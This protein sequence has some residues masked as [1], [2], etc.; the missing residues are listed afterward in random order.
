MDDGAV[1]PRMVANRPVRVAHGAT[2][3]D[4]ELVAN[5]EIPHVDHAAVVPD[6]SRVLHRNGIV[7][8]AAPITDGPDAVVD[9]ARRDHVEGGAAGRL[10]HR[11]VAGQ[12]GEGGDLER[13]PSGTSCA[14]TDS[15][16]PTEIR[17]ATSSDWIGAS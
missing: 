2:P 10:A 8:A 16:R 12:I 4:D 7:P 9:H 15:C 11:E 1:S 14:E 3:A 5:P 6:R 13:P 17:P